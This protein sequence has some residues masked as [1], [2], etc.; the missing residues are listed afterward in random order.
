[1]KYLHA[2]QNLE[3]NS[4]YAKMRNRIE[5]SKSYEMD[6]SM[7]WTVSFEDTASCRSK[8]AWKTPTLHC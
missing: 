6:E 3:S 7:Q 1:M 8:E 4:I 2:K 5:F